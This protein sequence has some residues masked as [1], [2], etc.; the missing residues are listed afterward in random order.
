MQALPHPSQLAWIVVMRVILAS[1]ARPGMPCAFLMV[2]RLA[3]PHQ[4]LA[5]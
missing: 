1:G 2:V 3:S 4:V 5:E